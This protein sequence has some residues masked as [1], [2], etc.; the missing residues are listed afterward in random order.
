EIDVLDLHVGDLDAPGL[1]ALVEDLLNVGVQFLT[2]GQQIVHLVLAE[3]GAQRGL[4]H[5]AGGLV[6]VRNLDDR[7]AGI[8]HS[9]VHHRVDFDRDVVAGDDI[10]FGHIQHDD[11]QVHLAHLLQH[12]KY[13]HH[14]RTFDAGKATER[15]H[16]A[17][18][19]LV[20]H[21]QDAQQQQQT[22]DDYHY[23]I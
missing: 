18:L 14:T 3:H 1:G 13:E 9:E 21:P 2:L 6:G 17:A 23:S 5:L 11:A 20:Q 15:E 7:L 22:K 16:D 12:R 19:V 8:H 10:L 4:R